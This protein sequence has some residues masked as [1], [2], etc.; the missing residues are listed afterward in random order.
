MIR[1]AVIGVGHL[2]KEHARIY[3]TLE[4]VTLVGVADVDPE[5]AKAIAKIV[6]VTPY[7]SHKDI[8]QEIDAVSI[9]TPTA[10]HHE[11]A[12]YFLSRNK[13]AFIEKPITQTLDEADE[14]VQLAQKNKLILSIGHVE[15][16]NPVFEYM[17][18]KI[19]APRF[20]EIHRLSQFPFRSL[21]IDV[22]MD[23]MI[24]DIDLVL[25]LVKK[26]IKDVQAFGASVVTDKP[27]IVNARVTFSDGCVANLTAS[28]ISDKA[29]RKMRIFTEDSY[30]SL[31]FLSGEVKTCK[32]SPEL[33]EK[34]ISPENLSKELA[35]KSRDKLFSRLLKFETIKIPRTT[36]PLKKE[37]GSFVS[38][39]LDGTQPVVSGKDARDVLSVALQISQRVSG[40]KSP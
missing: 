22:V 6:N 3:S 32:K 36:E 12:K 16:F 21:D 31:D 33:I 15:R 26:D 39:V 29:M 14:L 24:H 17:Q 1:I 28:R 25:Q 8:T 5:R 30:Y 11:I 37:L 34:T 23:V 9:A 2:G 20:I 4:N 38:S 27:D 7:F 40:V 10:T 35:N 19:K 13:H 18:E